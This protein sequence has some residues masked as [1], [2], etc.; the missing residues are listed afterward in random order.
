MWYTRCPSCGTN[1]AH[2]E[3]D[4]EKAKQKICDNPKLTEEQKNEQKSKLVN[5]LGLV[6]YCCKSRVL[7]CLDTVNIIK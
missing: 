7:T 1:L 3:L 4:Y 5:S 2:L 6:R